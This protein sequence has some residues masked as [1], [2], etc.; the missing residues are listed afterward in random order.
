MY[1]CGWQGCEKAYGTL[2]HLNAHV[3]MQSHGQKRTPEGTFSISIAKS[4]LRLG[5]RRWDLALVSRVTQHEPP[6]LALTLYRSTPRLHAGILWG[7]LVASLAPPTNTNTQNSRRYA[8]SGSN[9]RR[10]RRLN[11]RRK[12]NANAAAKEASRSTASPMI[13]RRPRRDRT[14]LLV[15]DLTYLP[16]AMHQPKTRCN[17]STP[18]VSNKCT[19]PRA[20]AR[21]MPITHPIHPTGSNRRCKSAPSHRRHLSA[22]PH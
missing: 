18:A 9:A 17:R 6:N 10:R 19:R 15:D 20:T 5:P 1:K 7:T 16:L 2:N 22:R 4:R 21:C 12:T 3:T 8:K 13:L 14:M 11:E